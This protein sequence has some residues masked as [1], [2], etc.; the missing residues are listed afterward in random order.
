MTDIRWQSKTSFRRGTFSGTVHS[1]QHDVHRLSWPPTV[2][3]TSRRASHKAA[4]F[5]FW[6]SVVIPQES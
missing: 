1:P 3:R 5:G 4:Q 6:S 2:S